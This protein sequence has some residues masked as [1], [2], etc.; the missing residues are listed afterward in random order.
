[1]ST[2]VIFMPGAGADPTFW[3]PVGDLLPATWNK[4]YL[5]WPGLGDNPPSSEV[6]SFLDMVRFTERHL[7][8]GPV[9]LVAQSFGG[10]VA[11]CVALR[12]P[13]RVER[14]VLATS[15]AGLNVSHHG[16]EDWRPAYRDEYPDASEWIYRATSNVDDQLHTVNQR[17]L[18]IWGDADPISPVAVGRHLESQL[19]FAQLHVIAGG[20]HAL[21]NERA[22]EV[23]PLIARHLGV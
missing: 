21:A 10:A 1:M 17:T 20:T 8:D 11:L 22:A 5:A 15:A 12:N 7:P 3:R 9:N 6:A 18:L 4:T 19:P 16:V 23:A 2:S 13:S 14:L